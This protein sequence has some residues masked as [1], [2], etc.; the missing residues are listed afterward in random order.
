MATTRDD[1]KKKKMEVGLL[2]GGGIRS[3]V[4]YQASMHMSYLLVCC[5]S[6]PNAIQK[7]VDLSLEA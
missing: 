3:A 6:R 1:A 5:N 7:V 4:V 2:C